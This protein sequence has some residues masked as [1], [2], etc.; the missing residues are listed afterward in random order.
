MAD[1]PLSLHQVSIRF[2][3]FIAVDEVSFEIP[4]GRIV[5][6]AGPN[7]SGKTTLLRAMFGAQHV[8]EGEIKVFDKPIDTLRT[9]E[10]G[11]KISVV[12]QFENT[13]DRMRVWDLVL[14]GRSPHRRDTQGYSKE[15]MM[16]ASN[17]L[18][19]VGMFDARN[20]YVDTL[21]G[22][23]RQRI[24]IARSL[25]QQSS[26]M[27]LDEPTNHLDVKYQHQILELIR[28]VAKTAVIILHDLNLVSRYCD[29][30]IILSRGRVHCK[31]NP[32]EILN[33]HLINEVYSVNAK[34]VVDDGVKQ[35]V[36]SGNIN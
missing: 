27:L 2:G 29:E 25:T 5:G 28:R 30:A 7:G 13:T 26:C 15:D 19:E 36:F 1:F 18:V 11:R 33:T 9:S 31:G 12:S 24:L 3:N 14:L 35:F 32:N 17:S 10:I 22:G 16:I 23:E 20:R 21:S 8:N 34:E 6:I 4:K